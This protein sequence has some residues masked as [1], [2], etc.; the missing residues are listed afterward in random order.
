MEA[1]T[2]NYSEVTS[3]VLIT[4]RARELPFGLAGLLLAT[5]FH[6]TGINK[7]SHW[8]NV[9]IWILDFSIGLVT[10]NKTKVK[11]RQQQQSRMAV[12]FF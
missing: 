12:S 1:V 5:F 9:A 2:K 3:Y 6:T 7:N 4:S 10:L 8:A 11:S